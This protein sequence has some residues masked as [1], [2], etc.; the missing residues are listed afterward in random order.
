MAIQMSTQAK[1][2]LSTLAPKDRDE[3][4]GVIGKLATGK[5]KGRRIDMSELPEDVRSS[6]EASSRELAGRKSVRS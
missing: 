4:L 2:F 1:M 3:F 6:I 5:L